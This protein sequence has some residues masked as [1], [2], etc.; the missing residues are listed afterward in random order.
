MQFENK[1]PNRVLG[2]KEEVGEGMILIMGSM[3]MY[4]VQETSPRRLHLKSGMGSTCS[5]D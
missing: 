5:F 1:V 3:I 4:A 2:P